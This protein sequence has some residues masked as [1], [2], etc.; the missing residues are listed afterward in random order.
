MEIHHYDVLLEI[1]L[2]NRTAKTL[3]NVHVELLSKGNL[4]IMDKPLI[5]TLRAYASVTVK[6]SIKVFATANC[7]IFGYV[8]Y[9]SASGNVPNVI[10]L[11]SIH[12][13]FMEKLSPA[14]CSEQEFKTMWADYEW[15]NRV[16]V[17][18]H[19]RYRRGN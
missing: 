3:P 11:N 8:T 17:S 4:K 9:D 18:T 16:T 1:L 5:Q 13:D 19:Y 15:E 14:N 6:A 12:L 2:I 10:T 7:G